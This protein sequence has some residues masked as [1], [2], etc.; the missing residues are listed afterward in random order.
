MLPDPD[1]V[2]Q[3]VRRR[4]V[5]PQGQRRAGLPGVL[6]PL[7]LLA[8][9]GPRERE[10]L[11]QRRLHERPEV[12][13]QLAGVDAD[14]R[15]HEAL[16]PQALEDVLVVVVRR[17]PDQR[18][19]RARQALLGQPG[20]GAVV[21]DPEPPSAPSSVGRIRKFPGCGS[22]CSIPARAGPSNRNRT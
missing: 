11:R 13:A 21:D 10:R 9:P 17:D 1:A 8:H 4:Q 3:Q 14:V 18:A 7:E 15:L 16:G 6:E 12:V 5:Q 2:D 19:H 20:H 22:A